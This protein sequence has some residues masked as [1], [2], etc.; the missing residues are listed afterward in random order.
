MLTLREERAWRDRREQEDREWREQ[1]RREDQ[2]WKTEQERRA[3]RRN[4]W[5]TFWAIVV[6][7]V[8]A[9]VIVSAAQILGPL[10]AIQYE[11]SSS[12]SIYEFL[13]EQATSPRQRP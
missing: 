7:G 11:K 5:Q 4:K 6:T 3:D 8:L 1:V 10:L 12:F 2:E 9:T 13:K